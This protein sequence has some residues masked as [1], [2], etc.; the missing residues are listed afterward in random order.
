MEKCVEKEREEFV[1]QR[2]VY[3]PVGMLAGLMLVILLV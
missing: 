2:S 3:M 1:R